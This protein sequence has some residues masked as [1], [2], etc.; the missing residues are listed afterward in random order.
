MK[1][2]LC[3]RKSCVRDGPDLPCAMLNLGFQAFTST[4]TL[5]SLPKRSPCA[6]LWREPGT[7][8]VIINGVRTRSSKRDSSHNTGTSYKEYSKTCTKQLEVSS[9]SSF[10]E[11]IQIIAQSPKA[12]PKSDGSFVLTVID[13]CLCHY[14]NDGSVQS[15]WK[16]LSSA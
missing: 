13:A 2:S 15:S 4:V 8:R 14:R 5:A 16:R 3:T 6:S 1:R 7:L 10:S 9:L 12:G 11:T